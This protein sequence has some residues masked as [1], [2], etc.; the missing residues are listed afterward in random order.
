[1]KKI[2]LNKRRQLQLHLN[3]LLNKKSNYLKNLE[4]I[5][6]TGIKIE[7]EKVDILTNQLLIVY[8]SF[9]FILYL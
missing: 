4:K 9:Y 1:M 6:N 3:N 2:K 8:I 7:N 5:N